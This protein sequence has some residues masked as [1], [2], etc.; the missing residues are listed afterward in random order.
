MPI[1]VVGD[2]HTGH[3]LH[4]EVRTAITGR[5]RLVDRRDIG[6]IHHRQRFAFDIEARHHLTRVHAGFDHLDGDT[7][8]RHLLLGEIHGAHAAFAEET[9]DAIGA[10]RIGAAFG[11]RPCDGRRIGRRIVGR[12]G[13]D[14]GHQGRLAVSITL[15]L[16]LCPLPFRVDSGRRDWCTSGRCRSRDAPCQGHRGRSR[17]ADGDTRCGLL[18]VFVRRGFFALSP[19]SA[20]FSPCDR[21]GTPTQTL[22]RARLRSRRAPCAGCD[23]RSASSPA[24]RGPSVPGR[25]SPVVLLSQAGERCVAALPCHVVLP[26][27]F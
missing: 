13:D 25:P 21:A 3:V 14:R 12:R 18:T 10:N 20:G 23:C 1:A 16:G 27:G 19:Y 6:M 2:R 17:R 24:T 8:M 15:L 5:A 22:A 26:H 4:R 11:W 9:Q 7:A